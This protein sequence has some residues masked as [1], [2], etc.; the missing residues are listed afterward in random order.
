MEQ[1]SFVLDANRPSHNLCNCGRMAA[2]WNDDDD[3]AEI[4]RKANVERMDHET[5]LI[6]EEMRKTR[7]SFW[8]A[9]DA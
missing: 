2:S 6:V 9:C 8:V 1:K 5:P 3:P 7:S 4:V